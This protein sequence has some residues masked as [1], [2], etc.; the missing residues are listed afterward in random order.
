MTRG[1]PKCDCVDGHEHIGPVERWLFSVVFLA[2][3]L[4]FMKPAMVGQLVN[5]ANAYSTFSLH[6]DA[7]RQYK[8]AIILDKTNGYAWIGLGDSLKADGQKEQ[9]IKAYRNAVHIEPKNSTIFFKLGMI[10]TLDERYDTAAIYFE[11]A[12]E[13]GPGV[14]GCRAGRFSYYKASLDMLALCFER[15]G[16]PEKAIEILKEV[17]QFCPND[18]RA[19]IKL[20]ALE[21]VCKQSRG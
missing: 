18:V 11:H 8:K 9:A 21:N 19:Q 5:R 15:L 7:I 10:Y 1:E 17:R 2:V 20:K 12:R 6:D 3:V 13:L 14:K 16:K 4:F